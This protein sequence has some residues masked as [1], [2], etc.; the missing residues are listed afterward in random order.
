MAAS[1]VA[2]GGEQSCLVGL[3][4]VGCNEGRTVAGSPLVVLAVSYATALISPINPDQVEA[5]TAR[6][7]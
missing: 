3:P 5:S 1:D 2:A 7:G 4:V 6:T